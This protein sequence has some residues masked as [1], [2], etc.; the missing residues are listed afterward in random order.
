MSNKIKILC[1]LKRKMT[2]QMTSVIAK[3]ERSVTIRRSKVSQK[4]LDIS[5]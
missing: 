4:N 5:D 3:L 1:H 2:P